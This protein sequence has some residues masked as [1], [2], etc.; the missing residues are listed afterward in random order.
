MRARGTP[1]R[2]YWRG[3]RKGVASDGEYVLIPAD[4]ILSSFAVES[5]GS[6]ESWSAKLGA[7]SQIGMLLLVAFGYF[8]TVRPVFQHQLL[9]EQAAKLEIEKLEIERGLAELNQEK[10]EAEN[11]LVSLRDALEREKVERK[12][13]AIRLD[14]ARAK[15]K[16]ARKQ[17][18]DIESKVAKELKAL[19]AARWELLLLDFMF[20]HSL[21]E[22]H[23][24]S[25]GWGKSERMD[26]YI[27]AQQNSWPHPYE[28]LAVAVDQVSEKNGGKHEF[29]KEYIDELRAFV[30]AR[31]SELRCEVPDFEMMAH[32][33]R[34]EIAGLS[35]DV[36]A[37]LEAF[38]SGVI[39]NYKEKG[40]RVMI[41]DDYRE[42]SRSV[43]RIN[44]ELE[45]D[46]RYRDELG[47]QRQSCNQ[48]ASELIDEFRKIKGATR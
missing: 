4:S 8:Y 37:E 22:L 21:P 23:R 41:T 17:A 19:E 28:D 45:V 34:A 25:S 47:A 24:L 33:Y 10:A 9:Q 30:E 27:L 13:L 11:D 1:N 14:N 20:A 18:Q 38:I 5:G 29:P 6:R 2:L 44:E 48:R 36:D 40:E 3:R 43:I 15:E 35:D 42:S 26:Q 39:E 46:R 31:K 7:W 32:R 12:K 16:L